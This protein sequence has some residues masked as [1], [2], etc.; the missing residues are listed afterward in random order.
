VSEHV[1][2]HFGVE[3]VKE[4]TEENITEVQAFWDTMGETI[5][6]IGYSNIIAD[7]E[8]S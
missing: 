1:L 6:G 3:E 8:E 7:W 4:L 2:S 5:M